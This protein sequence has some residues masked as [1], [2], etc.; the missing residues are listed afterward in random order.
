M[1][2]HAEEWLYRGLGG[3]NPDPAGP[4]FKKFIVKPQPQ[5][6]LTSVDTQYH[7]I[8]GLIASGWQQSAAGFTMTVAVPVNTTAT[9]TVPTSNPAAVT[10]SG[11]PAATASG[12]TSSSQIAGAL[13]LEVG[14]GHYTFAAAP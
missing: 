9:V 2:G 10:E 11:G 3:I 13:V 6:G 7:S 5:T 1:L 12:V 14:S 4:G 8:R